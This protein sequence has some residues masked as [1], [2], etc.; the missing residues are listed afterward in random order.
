MRFKTRSKSQLLDARRSVAGLT[1]AVTRRTT[2]S[3]AGPLR[4][5]DPVTTGPES[6][7]RGPLRRRAFNLPP[8]SLP[9][10]R[11]SLPPYLPVRLS[12]GRCPA[13]LRVSKLGRPRLPAVCRVGTARLRHGARPERTRL[14]SGGG[15]GR[16]VRKRPCGGSKCSTSPA[17]LAC[18]DANARKPLGAGSRCRYRPRCLRPHWQEPGPGTADD[19]RQLLTSSNC[20]IAN[21]PAGEASHRR[22]PAPPG[23]EATAAGLRAGGCGRLR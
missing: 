8:P 16:S 20:S 1:A 11:A 22:L 5:R 2:G 3:A 14:L 18:H 21:E 15:E 9:P 10:S 23:A 17:Q 7:G 6:L 19:G 12:A 4:R 13:L